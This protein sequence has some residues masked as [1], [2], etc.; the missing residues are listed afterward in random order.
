MRAHHL[1]VAL[2]VTLALTGC[3]SG[4]DTSVTAP[5]TYGPDIGGA[6]PAAVPDVL[7]FR[8][9]A[10][11]GKPF[12]GTALAGKPAALWFYGLSCVTCHERAREFATT[13]D[14]YLGAVNVVG[15][16]EPGNSE[17]LREFVSSTNAGNFPHLV[18]A[19]QE[20]RKRFKVTG[21]S[22]YVFLDRRGN[23]VFHGDNLHGQRLA[24]TF[25]VVAR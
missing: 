4:R 16:A 10:L 5:G 12:D 15:V 23:T 11:D 3:G 22:A 1:A 18:D 17:H 21:E 9:T 25:E 2:L 13:A 8:T 20:I 19:G 7:R 6:G 24:D 14:Q